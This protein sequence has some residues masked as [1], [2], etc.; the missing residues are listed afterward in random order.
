MLLQMLHTYCMKKMSDHRKQA[1]LGE[2]AKGVGRCRAARNV[3]ID[4]TTIFR[5]MRKD[6][7]FA[8]AVERAEMEAAQ[9]AFGK[10][11]AQRERERLRK[12][13]IKRRLGLTNRRV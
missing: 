4:R 13:E 11:K 5:T 7:D 12:Q 9:E 2:I 1:Y 6:K 8:I 10:K 3:G